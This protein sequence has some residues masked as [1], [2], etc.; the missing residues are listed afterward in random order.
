MKFLKKSGAILLAFSIACVPTMAHGGRTDSRGGHKDNKNASGLGSY[1]YHCG[2]YPAH[3]HEGGVCPYAGTPK[4][5][6]SSSS[7]SASNSSS[8]KSY[9]SSKPV[10]PKYVE[11][12]VKF[13][14]SGQST[15][16]NG[17][18]VNNTNLVELKTLC[19]KLGIGITWDNATQTVEGT[20]G[21]K[22]FKLTIGNKGATVNG[23]YITMSA[24]PVMYNGRT[25]VPA[26]TIA[27]AIGKVV[28]YNES[29]DTITIA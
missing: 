2:G 12:T 25:M 6:S 19:E 21:G 5:S 8:S 16:I 23:N 15:S 26:R 27:E 17:I 9:S 4:T 22:T 14:I 13:N 1:H 10:A 3:L 24:A 7:S 18:V 11:K 28:T 29:T 20:K